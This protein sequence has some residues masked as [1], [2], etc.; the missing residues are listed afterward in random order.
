MVKENNV[1]KGKNINWI[2]FESRE[3]DDSDNM[4][5]AELV[6]RDFAGKIVNDSRLHFDVWQFEWELI[7]GEKLI[8]DIQKD[9]EN[10]VIQSAVQW[11]MGND[12][13]ESHSDLLLICEHYK[14]HAPSYLHHFKSCR[15]RTELSATGAHKMIYNF[16][17]KLAL[18]ILTIE[19]PVSMSIK[20]L[21]DDELLKQLS[22]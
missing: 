19:K 9:F 7:A 20:K 8:A 18:R 15:G 2:L 10:A 3:F 6:V 1:Y 12:D 14:V 17:D 11:A 13:I 22:E 4:V 16:L 5:N 21:S